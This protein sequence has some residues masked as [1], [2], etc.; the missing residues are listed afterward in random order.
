MPLSAPVR[1]FKACV[2]YL[3]DPLVYYG[4]KG[5]QRLADMPPGVARLLSADMENVRLQ[6]EL[7]RTQWQKAE[8]ESLR[9]ENRRLSAALGLTA[10]VGRS[11]IWADVMERDPLHW[12]SNIMVNV[13][14]RQGVALNAPV[15]GEKDGEIIVIGR[16]TEVRS[17]TSIVLLVTDEL[18][19]IAVYLSSAGVDGLA[20]G[21]GGPRLRVNYL[22][23]EAALTKGDLIYTS[24]T[25]A[26]FPGDVLVGRVTAVNPSD[27][28]LTFQSVEVQPAVNSTSLNN[29]M[30][31]RPEGI[32]GE[33]AALP[34][35]APAAA[36][37]RKKPAVKTDEVARSTTAPEGR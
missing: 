5:V 20:Q 10:P 4:D 32:A 29:V 12:Y 30:I 16:V 7:R 14:S 26:T 22:P 15:F 3:F 37:P 21:Q 24:Q 28:F 2:V 31:L 19:S 13:G 6:A 34:P 11:A 25:S 35:A 36:A 8:L 18:S 23:S 33:P 1:A 27:P 9:N 17:D